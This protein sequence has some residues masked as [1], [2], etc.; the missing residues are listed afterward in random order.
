MRRHPECEDRCQLLEHKGYISCAS[1]GCAMLDMDLDDFEP[2][3]PSKKEDER[4]D[5]PRHGQAEILNRERHVP[6]LDN[7]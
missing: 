6:K 2:D 3:Y 4:L 5:D 7:D 1:A